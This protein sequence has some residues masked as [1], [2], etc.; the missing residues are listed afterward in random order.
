MVLNKR[1]F[2]TDIFSFLF[3]IIL[4]CVVQLMID[5]KPSLLTD[6]IILISFMFGLIIFSACIMLFSYKNNTDK[7]TVGNFVLHILL[8][9]VFYCFY[10]IPAF[11]FVDYNGVG[12][13]ICI[14]IVGVFCSKYAFSFSKYAEVHNITGKIKL[15]K[16]INVDLMYSK[17]MP[18][19]LFEFMKVIGF[20]FLIICTIGLVYNTFNP[21][22]NIA[23]YE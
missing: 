11:G 21:C 8:S 19:K 13:S 3:G 10:S 16:D 7:V 23:L 20:V 22:F 15:N 4:L 9:L 2:I 6:K 12:N 18:Y 1:L 17:N 5:F 14:A